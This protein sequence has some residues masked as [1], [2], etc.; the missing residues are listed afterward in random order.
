MKVIDKN[1]LVN[2]L[3]ESAIPCLERFFK[4]HKEETFFGFAVEILAEEGYF[5][6]GASS[7]ESFQTIV[8]SYSQAGESMEEILG[9]GIKWNN[10]EWEYFNLNYGSEVWDNSWRP[11]LTKIDDYKKYIG[12]LDDKRRGKALEDFSDAFEAAAR[13]AFQRI[14]SSGI[15]EKIKKTSDFRAFVFEHHE[16]F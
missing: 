12:S 3:Y 10:Q 5:H 9:E 1:E 2:S 13:E 14:V 6:I 15:L 8:D 4:E 7:L 16:V 11:M